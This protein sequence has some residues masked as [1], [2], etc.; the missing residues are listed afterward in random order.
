MIVLDT[1]V[2]V[3][4]VDDDARLGRAARAASEE[5][6]RTDGIGV[7]AITPWEIAL[8]A[9]RGRLRLGRDVGV[10]ID[11]ALNLPG[12]HL[13]PIEPAVAIDSVREEESCR[14]ASTPTLP[15][16][17]SWRRPAIAPR[18]YSPPT[19]PFSSTPR[20]ASNAAMF[21]A[22]RLNST[23]IRWIGCPRSRYLSA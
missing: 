12:V 15:I 11:T 14:A 23:P 3:W 5:A 16:A 7:S 19:G 1:H 10:W 2:L 13:I 20:E 9:E 4:A 6:G 22:S 17:S 21:R 8:L 18:R